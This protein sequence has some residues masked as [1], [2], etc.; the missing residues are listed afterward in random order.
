VEDGDL[1]PRNL[2]WKHQVPLNL[3]IIG[4]NP[5]VQEKEPRGR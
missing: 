4:T 2:H 3:K 1:N 5:C